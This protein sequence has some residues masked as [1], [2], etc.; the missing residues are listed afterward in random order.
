MAAVASGT[1]QALPGPAYFP[2]P[3]LSPGCAP[4]P[5]PHGRG[6]HPAPL[7]C[8]GGLQPSLPRAP[9]LPLPEALSQSRVRLTSLFYCFLSRAVQAC[10]AASD[11]PHSCH[12]LP[13]SPIRD[14]FTSARPGRS[15]A[16]R[17]PAVLQRA[18]CLG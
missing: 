15:A 7:C 13:P 14:Y 12:L 5:R 17:P 6:W 4:P 10:P 18:P 2:D 1:R 16:L 3:A 8:K 11:G 9:F